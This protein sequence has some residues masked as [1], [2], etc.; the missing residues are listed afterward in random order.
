M[1]RRILGA[2]ILT[3]VGCS[4]ASQLASNGDPAPIGMRISTDGT[5]GYTEENPV[6]VGGAGDE[7]GPSNERA[8]LAA[9]RGPS[10]Q[11]VSF[12]RRGSCCVFKT[13]NGIM[14]EGGLLDIYEVTYDGQ[15]KPTTLYLNMYDYEAPQVPRGFTRAPHP[16][17][18]AMLDRHPSD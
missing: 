10:G 17:Q 5:Y 2:L 11:V 7:R 12:E 13:K 16:G 18:S 14:G 3:L 1:G 15:E 8:Y 6:K 9:L 4:T